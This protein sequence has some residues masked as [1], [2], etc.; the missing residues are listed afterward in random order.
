MG[1]GQGY[2]TATP[3]QLAKATSILVNNGKVMTPHLMKRIEGTT[4]EPYQDPKLYADITEPKQYY[5]DVAKRGMYNVVN[6]AAGTG[7]KAFAGA[8]YRVAGKSG[9]A[10]VVSFKEN[11]SYNAGALKKELHDH[12][13]FTAFAPYDK[14]KVVVSIILE[15]AGGGSSNAAPLVRK[16][17]DYYF[18]QTSEPLMGEPTDFMPAGVS[19]NENE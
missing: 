9:T 10:Q 5:W 8:P 6:S 14:P 11:Q 16:I 7:R 3:L 4:I 17:M 1:I 2:W 13:W 18:R 19:T 12:A 15:N